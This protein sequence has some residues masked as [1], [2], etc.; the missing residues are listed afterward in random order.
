MSEFKR[1]EH[2]TFSPT[3]CVACGDHVGPFI[4]LEVELPVY[5][6]LYLCTSNSSRSG[7]VQQIA[8]L[9]AMVEEGHLREAEQVI[10][11]LQE[12]KE[13]L[14]RSL[15]EDKV[16]SLNDVLALVERP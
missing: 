3:K 16:V 14:K 2:A 12:E 7:C 5:G 10:E 8:R 4:D 1:V 9:D 13:G 6:H 15:R 11:S